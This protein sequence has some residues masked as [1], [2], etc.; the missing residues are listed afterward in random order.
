MDVETFTFNVKTFTSFKSDSDWEIENFLLLYLLDNVFR[1][2]SRGFCQT[3]FFLW[4]IYSSDSSLIWEYVGHF[5]SLMNIY[6]AKV[7]F[8]IVYLVR[9]CGYQV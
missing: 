3:D 7:T 5:I 6:V 1:F 4:N 9:S 8:E 2:F